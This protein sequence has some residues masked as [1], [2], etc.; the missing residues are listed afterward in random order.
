LCAR[1]MRAFAL[2]TSHALFLTFS[3]LEASPRLPPTAISTV[4]P[5]RVLSPSPLPSFPCCSFPSCAGQGRTQRTMIVS[6]RSCVFYIHPVRPFSSAHTRPPSV[7]SIAR[8]SVWS[9]LIKLSGSVYP[10]IYGRMMGQPR[11]FNWFST[12][13]TDYGPGTTGPQPIAL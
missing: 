3:P 10:S 8:D 12:V 4:I 5:Y 7:C 11:A 1:I 9:V 2:R 6:H 13:P